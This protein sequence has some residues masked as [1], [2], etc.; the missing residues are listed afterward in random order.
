[1]SKGNPIDKFTRE[2]LEA[3]VE[4]MNANIDRLSHAALANRR[5]IVG[6]KAMRNNYLKRIDAMKGDK[7]E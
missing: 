2:Q 1:M 4:N 6:I 3:G 5:E 7:N